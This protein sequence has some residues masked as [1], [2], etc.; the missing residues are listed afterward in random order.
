MSS[1]H[2]VLSRLLL[3]PDGL[4]FVTVAV[5]ALV[6]LTYLI[7]TIEGDRIAR[8]KK[9]GSKPPTLPFL[10]PLLGHLPEFISD[11]RKFLARVS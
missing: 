9:H 4:L 10:I 11:T 1:I 7:S 3:A 8:N 2:S 5:L 6:G